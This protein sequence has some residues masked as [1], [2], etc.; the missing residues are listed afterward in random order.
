MASEAEVFLRDPEIDGSLSTD[1]ISAQLLDAYV[2]QFSAHLGSLTE[3]KGFLTDVLGR[4]LTGKRYEN[5][6]LEERALKHHD[7]SYHNGERTS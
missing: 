6:E 4:Q 2:A 5:L 7:R 1:D 3:D